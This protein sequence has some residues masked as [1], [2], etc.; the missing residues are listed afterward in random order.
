MFIEMCSLKCFIEIVCSEV[1]D[2]LATALANA[3]G[4]GDSPPSAAPSKKAAPVRRS[5]SVASV[6]TPLKKSQLLQDTPA[7]SDVPCVSAAD[8]LAAAMGAAP[9]GSILAT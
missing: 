1:V 2:S 3:L 7:K 5:M 8:A 6:E 4:L 9:V